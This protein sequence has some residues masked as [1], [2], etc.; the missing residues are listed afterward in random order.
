VKSYKGVRADVGI[1]KLLCIRFSCILDRSSQMKKFLAVVLVIFLQTT[2][3]VQGASMGAMGIPATHKTVTAPIAEASDTFY[4]PLPNGD[5]LGSYGTLY[6]LVGPEDET[7]LLVNG[8]RI[9]PGGRRY[10]TVRAS[11]ERLKEIQDLVDCAGVDGA[12]SDPIFAKFRLFN[13][14]VGRGDLKAVKH[15]IGEG[16]DVNA[17]G[18]G[19]ETHLLKACDHLRP[20][21]LKLLLRHCAKGAVNQ[22]NTEG[23]TPLSISFTEVHN[24]PLALDLIEALVGAGADAAMAP[25]GMTP[26][27][28]LLRTVIEVMSTITEDNIYKAVE[29]LLTHGGARTI[30]YIHI[31]E[32]V[33]A[34]S[35]AVALKSLRLVNLLLAHGADSALCATEKNPL[36]GAIA[37]GQGE[38]ANALLHKLFISSTP[39]LTIHPLT[40]M[41]AGDKATTLL[42]VLSLG[43]E[44]CK[45]N[46][47]RLCHIEDGLKA[48]ALKDGKGKLPEQIMQDP[49]VKARMKDLRE[50]YEFFIYCLRKDISNDLKMLL[51]LQSIARNILESNAENMGLYVLH[52]ARRIVEDIPIA[53]ARGAAQELILEIESA[54]EVLKCNV[55]SVNAP[56]T[57]RK[58]KKDLASDIPKACA[59]LETQYA[60]AKASIESFPDLRPLLE[61]PLRA[62]RSQ[63][64]NSVQQ[65][66]QKLFPDIAADKAAEKAARESASAAAASDSSEPAFDLETAA[67]DVETLEALLKAHKDKRTLL[68]GKIL[69]RIIGIVEQADVEAKAL[70]HPTEIVTDADLCQDLKEKYDS[71]LPADRTARLRKLEQ[72]ALRRYREN[73]KSTMGHATVLKTLQDAI[74]NGAIDAKLAWQMLSRAKEGPF[75]KLHQQVM[76]MGATD[77]ATVMSGGTRKSSLVGGDGASTLDGGTVAAAGRLS[78]VD[79]LL[80]DEKVDEETSSAMARFPMPATLPGPMVDTLQKLFRGEYNKLDQQGM[81]V[82]NLFNALGGGFEASYN[83][84]TQNLKVTY[85]PLGEKL[86]RESEDPRKATAFKDYTHR[87]AG[88]YEGLQFGFAGRCLDLLKAAGIETEDVTQL[89]IRTECAAKAGTGAAASGAK[90]ASKS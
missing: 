13:E 48:L 16:Y 37:L 27:I 38:I 49:I 84:A 56:E 30:N 89:A 29:I 80:P 50:G 73:L 9:S 86:A 62:L 19:G 44:N 70:G 59:A 79:D 68:K 81:D 72:N 21:M 18:L 85:R 11:G 33:T 88:G 58:R 23:L 25:N 66:I 31:T 32:K 5:R 34:L 87:P 74:G 61:A 26:L 3:M 39:V 22:A 77:M 67:L 78:E 36:A 69:Q 41:R 20:E 57:A 47:D 90:A 65:L 7:R 76:E 45:D 60:E 35:Y 53:Q 51:A 40:Y 14:L 2:H 71:T 83:R 6:R 1:K 42:H 17:K 28:G 10:Y 75:Y 52:K 63:Q 12:E 55:G 64:H 4:T 46:I 82:F 8:G 54:A 43:G 24:N 15:M